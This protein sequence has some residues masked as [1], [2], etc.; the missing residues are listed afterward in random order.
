MERS[1][2]DED[3]KLGQLPGLGRPSVETSPLLE[4]N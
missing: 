1:C 3:S 4:V 2:K